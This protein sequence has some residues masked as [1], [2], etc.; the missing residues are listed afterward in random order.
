[1]SD[2]PH[3]RIVRGNPT[4]EEVAALLAVVSTLRTPEEPSGPPARSAWADRR[5]LVRAPLAHGPGA[6]RA[7]AFPR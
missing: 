2:R 6:W 1:M 4:D 7:S 3:L 5:N